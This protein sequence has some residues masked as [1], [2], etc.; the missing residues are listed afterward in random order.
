M[1]S[2]N[3]DL[4][5]LLFNRLFNASVNPPGVYITIAELVAEIRITTQHAVTDDTVAH[6]LDRTSFRQH[7][8]FDGASPTN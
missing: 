4:D 2:L 1:T 6:A 7:Q 8:R 3:F 5:D